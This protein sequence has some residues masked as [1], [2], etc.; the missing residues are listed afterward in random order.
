M[1]L[2]ERD[3]AGRERREHQP[4]A[5]GG[6]DDEGD[7]DGDSHNIIILLA[8]HLYE[9]E[10]WQVIDQFETGALAVP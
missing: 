7:D 9:A 10:H 6:G 3:D 8:P 2:C 1:Q 4:E 5:E